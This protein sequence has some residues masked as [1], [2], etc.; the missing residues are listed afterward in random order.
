MVVPDG[1]RATRQIKIPHLLVRSLLIIAMFGF[2][3][4]GYLVFDYVELTGIRS[5]YHHVASENKSLKGE[6]RILM[7]NLEDVKR[8]LRHVQDFSAKL[9]ELTQLKVQKVKRK[10]GIGPLS[11]EEY[12]TALSEEPN[13]PSSKNYLPLSVNLDNLTFR[14][15]F[16]QLAEV[17]KASKTHAI[18]LQQLLSTLSQQKSLLSSVPSVSPVPS[19]WITSG[20]GIRISP[21]TGKRSIHRGLD[22]AG[23]I[24]TPIYAP[25]DG[26]VIFSGVKDGFGNFIMIAH[27]LGVV[28]RYGHNHQNTVAPGQKVRR[29]EQIATVGRTGRTT[30]PHLHYEVLVNGRNQNPKKFILD[31]SKIAIAH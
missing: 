20:Y 29:G 28:T 9:G 16:D 30:G 22:I 5:S 13:L 10:T 1:A 7:N 12:K 21:F 19:G 26:V 18:E 23:P 31:M 27:G 8:S 4:F 15:V 11:K 25:A 6:A 3:L 2:G 14:P 24:G 17:Q